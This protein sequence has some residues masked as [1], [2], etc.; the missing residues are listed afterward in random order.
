MK[1]NICKGTITA[2][3]TPFKKNL[4]IDFDALKKL[5]DFQIK[6]RIDAILVAGTTGESPALSKEE[7]FELMGKTIDFA[8][9]K[10]PVIA[11]TGSNNTK[12]TIELTSRAKELGVDAVL[13]VAPYYNKPT[14]SGLF[15]HYKTIANNVDIPQ[16]I[17]NVP[18]RTSVNILPETQLKIAEECKNVIGTKEASGNLGQMMEIIKNAP[19][20]F[21]LLSGDDAL[22]L[23]AISIGAKGCVSVLSNYAPVEFGRMIHFALDGKYEQAKKIHFGLFDLM[24]I[25]FIESS[26]IPVKYVLSQMG[27]IKELYRLPLV[28]L[29]SQNKSKI[30]NA[31]KKAG[32]KI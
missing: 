15:E 7:K 19:R 5:I 23:P 16:I 8:N 1:A 29:Q 28:P 4:E 3:V 13:I 14:Q 20:G 22:T 21:N 32:I 2:L 26:P 27:F 11:G 12:D 18:G 9:G 31:L 17:Y 24:N 10:I 6:S 25:N 30:T